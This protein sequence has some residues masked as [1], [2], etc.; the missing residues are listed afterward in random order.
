MDKQ[1]FMAVVIT[2]CMGIFVVMSVHGDDNKKTGLGDDIDNVQSSIDAQESIKADMEKE[3]ESLE[4]HKENLV[5]YMEELNKTYDGIQ[6]EIIALDEEIS[7]K[8]KQID[9]I[10]ESLKKADIELDEQYNAMKARIQYM[11]EQGNMDYITAF[12]T[13]G[14]IS[15]ALNQVEYISNIIEYDRDMMDKYRESIATIEVMKEELEK[16]KEELEKLKTTQQLKADELITFMNKASVNIK[17][18]E[19][20]ISEAESKALEKEKEIEQM[21]EY[22]KYLEEMES[23]IIAESIKQSIEESIA[24]SEA[25][26]RREEESR[27]QSEAGITTWEGETTKQEEAT[28][29]IVYDYDVKE[30]DLEKLSALIY[31]EAGGQPYE[32]KLAV[33]SV[34]MNRVASRLFPNTLDEVL[35]QPYQFSPVS[36]RKSTRL[37]SS[38]RL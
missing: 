14:N 2:I 5:K 17:N 12:L 18:K 1:K 27:K 23:S 33:G 32:G 8:Q 21:Y 10:N 13:S 7:Q 26:S 4:A 24:E 34:V 25:A 19:D 35:A 15:E 37:N 31:C 9:D 29:K 11:Y 16:Q 22:R 28:T 36:D 6:K 30:G 3:L 38:H 20:Q